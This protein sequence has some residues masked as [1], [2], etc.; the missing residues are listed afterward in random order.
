MSGDI[1]RSRSTPKGRHRQ[2]SI[3]TT[4][5]TANRLTRSTPLGA[6]VWAPTVGFATLGV[7]TVAAMTLVSLDQ[8]PNHAPSAPQALDGSRSGNPVTTPVA[9]PAGEMAAKAAQAGKLHTRNVSLETKVPDASSTTRARTADIV[10]TTQKVVKAVSRT[11]PKTNPAPLPAPKGGSTAPTSGG[12]T[13]GS[14]GSS[15]SGSTGTPVPAPVTPPPPPP[16]VGVNLPTG[17]GTSVDVGGLVHL[18]L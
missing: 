5:G 7:A 13:S 2:S 14:S 18:G 6:S 12:N 11:V 9:T 17:T 10:V 4:K 16:V 1:T 8:S 15:G 3:V